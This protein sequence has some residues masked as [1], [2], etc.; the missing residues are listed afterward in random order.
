M[1][2]TPYSKGTDQPRRNKPPCRKKEKTNIG[3][4]LQAAIGD[5]APLVGVVPNQKAL[6]WI[7]QHLSVLRS[8]T[9]PCLRGKDGRGFEGKQIP[10]KRV[11]VVTICYYTEACRY[12]LSNLGPA[13]HTLACAFLGGGGGG[14][15][16]KGPVITFLFLCVCVLVRLAAVVRLWTT[17]HTQTLVKN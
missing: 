11:R 14:E 7:R 9:G 10:P 17:K 1:Q 8:G 6:V 16:K 15:D 13:A 3:V 12:P 5:Q 2:N 4:Q